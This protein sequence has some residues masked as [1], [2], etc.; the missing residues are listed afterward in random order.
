MKFYTITDP[1]D[2]F[3]FKFKDGYNEVRFNSAEP[4]YK[5]KVIT[6][7][8]KDILAFI[9]KGP[10]LY[11]VRP[12]TACYGEL[13]RPAYFKTIAAKLKYVGK[14]REKIEFLIRQGADVNA[15]KGAALI[16]AIEKRDV[17]LVKIL[18]KHGAD[19][20]VR[21]GTPLM[22]ACDYNLADV[23]K[24]LIKRGANVNVGNGWP[25]WHCLLE[26]NFKLAKL[27][28]K[29]GADVKVSLS[30]FIN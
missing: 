18:V 14:L 21:K 16:Y 26:K 20:N 8:Q 30:N 5:Q 9:H 6:F 28:V 23:V 7:Y 15:G 3:S 19:V 1:N 22:L 10:D 11:E 24:I 17:E 12:V 27:L 2:P 29:Y 25:L 13:K 4:W